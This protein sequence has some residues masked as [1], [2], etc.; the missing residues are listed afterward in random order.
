MMATLWGEVLNVTI[1]LKI[2]MSTDESIARSMEN[3]V[4]VKKIKRGYNVWDN[5]DL[6]S[7]EITYCFSFSLDILTMNGSQYFTSISCIIGLSQ[8]L[9]MDLIMR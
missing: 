7:E 1:S 6:R 3:P 4:V 8:D 9:L 5:P 2:K